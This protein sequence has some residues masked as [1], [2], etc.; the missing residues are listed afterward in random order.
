MNPKRT[1]DLLAAGFGLI[2]F[3]PILAMVALIVVIDSPGPALFFQ[4][5]VGRGG[6]VFRIIKFRSM[7]A[8]TNMDASQLTIGNDLRI[9]KFGSLL[10]KWKVDELP[11]LWNVLK[12]D[13]SIVGPR[14]E[15]PKYVAHYPTKT[16]SIILSVRPGITDP[17]S[18]ILSNESAILS[19]ADDPHH[20]YI[21]VLLPKKLKI[22]EKY[23]ENQSFL[24]DTKII[25]STIIFILLQKY[26]D[27]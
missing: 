22:Y 4:D 24:F 18:L 17:C 1:F 8:S 13:M 6:T 19:N 5:R 16:R 21:K 20:Y 12:G 27:I 14:P 10:R 7:T 11:Q 3:A 9:T 15:V 23:V 2:F 25:I 26:K